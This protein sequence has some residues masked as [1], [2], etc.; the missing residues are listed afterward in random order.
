M[1]I[2][3]MS[4]AAF[5]SLV[6]VGQT[7]TVIERSTFKD[8]QKCHRAHFPQES[9]LSSVRPPHLTSKFPNRRVFVLDKARCLDPPNL[10]A[11]LVTP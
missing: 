7:Y 11:I 2:R 4:E 9:L 10:P 8:N 3:D 5:N 6:R 1:K